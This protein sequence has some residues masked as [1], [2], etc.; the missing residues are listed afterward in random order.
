MDIYNN[1]VIQIFSL[2]THDLTVD[3]HTLLPLPYHM[4]W[5]HYIFICSIYVILFF[6][7]RSFLR[8]LDLIFEFLKYRSRH[9]ITEECIILEDIQ[10]SQPRMTLYRD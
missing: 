1:I 9:N 5:H 6:T 10:H 8:I 3:M 2:A 4:I 7:I